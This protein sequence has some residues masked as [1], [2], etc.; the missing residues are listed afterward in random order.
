MLTPSLASWRKRAA[1]TLV[2]STYYSS[3]T[4]HLDESKKILGILYRS[5]KPLL[6]EFEPEITTEYNDCL[7]GIPH[8]QYLQRAGEIKAQYGTSVHSFG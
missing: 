5:M 3:L 4:G 2:E 7:K 8:D 1:E 6:D